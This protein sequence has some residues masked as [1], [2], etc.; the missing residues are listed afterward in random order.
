MDEIENIQ[1]G[2][3]YAQLLIDN[4]IEGEK[5]I[6]ASQQLPINLLTYWCEEIELYAD[7]TYSDY[8]TGKREHFTFD[9]DEFRGLFEKAGMRYTGDLLDGLVDDGL[10]DVLIRDDGEIVYQTNDKGKQAMDDYK[11]QNNK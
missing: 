3:D 1:S 5:E 7:Q 6:P 9:E 11:N 2:A 10:V 8:L 4:I